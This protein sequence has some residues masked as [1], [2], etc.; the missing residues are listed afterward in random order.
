MKK[1]NDDFYKQI[2]L[3]KEKVDESKKSKKVKKPKE[4]KKNG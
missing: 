1:I 4:V 3:L 2:M